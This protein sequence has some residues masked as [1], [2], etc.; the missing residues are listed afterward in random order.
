[1]FLCGINFKGNNCVLRKCSALLPA[2]SSSEEQIH[3]LKFLVPKYRKK[4]AV[5]EKKKCSAC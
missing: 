5:F 4:N 2:V 3:Y 1:M